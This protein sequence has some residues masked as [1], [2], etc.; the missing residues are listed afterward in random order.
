MYYVKFTNFWFEAEFERSRSI[1]LR[2]CRSIAMVTDPPTCTT[3]DCNWSSQTYIVHVSRYI[4]CNEQS[5]WT[6]LRLRSPRYLPKTKWAVQELGIRGKLDRARRAR[7]NQ[8]RVLTFYQ[9]ILYQNY[10]ISIQVH[11]KRVVQLYTLNCKLH[12]RKH[13]SCA[14]GCHFPFHLQIRFHLHGARRVDAVKQILIHAW[15][16]SWRTRWRVWLLIP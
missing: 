2:V 4:S 12:I 5:V 9:I 10:Y 3:V 16:A 8:I 14:D 15:R 6:D 7:A 11:I 13:G 1:G